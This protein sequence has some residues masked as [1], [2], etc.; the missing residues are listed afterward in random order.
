MTPRKRP[1]LRMTQLILDLGHRPALGE[2]DFLV[3]PCNQAAI[4]WLDRWPDWPARALT[5]QGPAGCGKTH[6]ARVFA[7]RSRASIVVAESLATEAV[8]T[9]LGGAGACVVDDADRAEAEPLLHLYNLIAERRGTMLLAA[10]EPPAR[11]PG[12]LPDLRSRLAAAPVVAV[13]PPDDALLAALMVKLFADR[14]LAVSEEVVLFLLRHM[15]RSF[16]AARRLVADLDATAL[17]ERRGITIP[18]AR[19]VLGLR[20]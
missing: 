8:P 17:R 3:A 12:L 5:L 14:Q 11:W 15:E 13:A 10:R 20:A 19:S 4:R 2:A 6:L 18:L 16:E 1:W 9:L 7:A